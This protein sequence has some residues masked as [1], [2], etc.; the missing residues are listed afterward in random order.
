MKANIVQLTDDQKAFLLAVLRFARGFHVHF[1]K[2]S[3]HRS[4]EDKERLI[5]ANRIDLLIEM[6]QAGAPDLEQ[7]A[8]ENHCLK[9]KIMALQLKLNLK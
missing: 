7:L 1:V 9:N 6:I 3:K 5:K 2:E 4:D 8:E